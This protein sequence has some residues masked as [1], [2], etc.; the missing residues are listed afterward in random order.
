MYDFIATG[1][2]APA[3]P[4]QNNPDAIK[5]GLIY[6]VDSV[7]PQGNFA[8]LN[9]SVDSRFDDI[10]N[11]PTLAQT[12][13]ETAT[14]EVFTVAVNHFKSKGSLTGKPEDQDQGDGQGNNNFTR[15]Q[16]AAALTDWLGT[17]P[18]ASND[19]DFLII[20]DLNAYAFEDPVRT[21]ENA[22]Y[23]NL[24][25]QFEG[26]DSYSYTFD[27]QNGSLDHALASASLRSQITGTTDWHI[28]ADEPLV[29]DYNDDIRD[30]GER[31]SDPLNLPQLFN[32]DPYRT[33][34]HDPVIIGLDLSSA[35]TPEPFTLQLFMRATKKR[36]LRPLMMLLG[37]VRYLRPYGNRTSM[38]MESLAMKTP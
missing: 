12:F 2:I 16:A 5:V 18:T 17:D 9:S 25:K 3:S 6:K 35:A 31:S 32:V 26:E 14:G 33:S 27:G 4:N 10:N 37:L 15:T 1:V 19:S 22:G 8:I 24:V 38:E 30:P 29:Y 20:G 7:T 13:S 36:E 34:D 11:R 23:V 28:N 21:I